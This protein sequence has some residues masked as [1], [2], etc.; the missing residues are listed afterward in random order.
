MLLDFLF[1]NKKNK[2][3]LNNQ[4]IG[5][6]GETIKAQLAQLQKEY[7]YVN[8]VLI[9]NPLSST[10]YSQI[11]YIIITPYGLFIIDTKNY[12]GTIFGSKHKKDWLINERFKMKNPLIQINNHIHALKR[13][14]N[15]QY[16]RCFFSMV[17]F[18]NNCIFEMEDEL[19]EIESHE[20]VIH[21]MELTHFISKKMD[22][23]QSQY[24]EP[25]ISKEEM[26]K[27]Y[28]SIL[29][30]NITDPSARK[31]HIDNILK[32]RNSNNEE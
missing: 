18:P 17:L 6:N 7:L 32:N 20:L 8:D 1:N 3:K 30:A 23:L 2:D 29:E 11:D 14:I 4:H 15:V 22:I 27:V 5:K 31:E 28:N 13:F 26:E 16:H 19:R 12:P 9:K 10:G 24:E 25:I 21:D